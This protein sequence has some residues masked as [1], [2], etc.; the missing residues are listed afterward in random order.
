M[1]ILLEELL[2]I[3]CLKLIPCVSINRFNSDLKHVH[4]RAPEGSI[5]GQLL[6]FI[7]SMISTVQL[8]IA[9]FIVL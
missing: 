1:T 6:V 7:H 4:C 8:N 3:T 2:F 5:L 9:Q